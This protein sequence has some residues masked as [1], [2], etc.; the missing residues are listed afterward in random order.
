MHVKMLE[1]DPSVFDYD[2]VVD[3]TKEE[4]KVAKQHEKLSRESRY[5]TQIMHHSK[6]REREQNVR[7][8]VGCWN[9][10]GEF[11]PA[12]RN[13]AYVAQPTA[14]FPGEWSG[15]SPR[16]GGGEGTDCGCRLCII[17]MSE[18][19]LCASRLR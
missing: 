15:V 11:S 9:W 2:G 5:I 10:E 13:R 7:G 16:R 4:R 17:E 14:F 6:G 1:E 8:R 18:G 19:K 12:V 3:N